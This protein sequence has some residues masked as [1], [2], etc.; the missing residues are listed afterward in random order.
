M[1]VIKHNISIDFLHVQ[2]R[3]DGKYLTKPRSL[4]KIHRTGFQKE[5][6]RN[7]CNQ[8][9]SNNI[10]KLHSD[11]SEKHSFYFGKDKI[12]RRYLNLSTPATPNQQ[13]GM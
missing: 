10:S 1:K 6:K 4:N 5:Q 13:S 11:K 3:F 12:T 8:K 7:K 9:K 2:T